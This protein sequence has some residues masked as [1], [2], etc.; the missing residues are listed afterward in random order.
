MLATAY[1]LFFNEHFQNFF[2]LL[3]P[4]NHFTRYSA[5]SVLCGTGG[6]SLSMAKPPNKRV[7]TS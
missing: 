6:G 5:A 2:A 7:D 4:E 1:C 3:I